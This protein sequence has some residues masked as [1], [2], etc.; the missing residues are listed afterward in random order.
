MGKKQ[1]KLKSC[2][3]Y[4]K[5]NEYRDLIKEVQGL[6]KEIDKLL[7]QKEKLP[8]VKDKV[9]ASQDEYPFIEIHVTV[10]AYDP[11]KARN[12]DRLILEKRNVLDKLNKKIFETENYINS[13]EDS[14]T[15]SIFRKVFIEGEPQNKVADELGYTPARINQII[16]QHFYSNNKI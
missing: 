14:I 16:R 9:R 8:V 2:Y 7:K 5:I 3:E 11:I 15:R 10:D 1:K 4:K 12:K 13:I 6:E